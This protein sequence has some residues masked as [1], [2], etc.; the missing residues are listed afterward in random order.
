MIWA[1][2]DRE[3]THLGKVFFVFWVFL[4]WV[5]VAVHEVSLVAGSGDYSL[6]VVSRLL[7]V[8]VTSLV[9]EHRL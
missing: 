4:H 6:V 3:N 1:V 8:G 7:I 5:C 9:T 2:G